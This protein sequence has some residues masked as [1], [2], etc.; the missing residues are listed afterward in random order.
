MDGTITG[1]T[2]IETSGG[3]TCG[4]NAVLGN[5]ISDAVQ[6]AG[7]AR[8]APRA[9]ITASGYAHL[10][11]RTLSATELEAS[12]SAGNYV[13]ITPH[14]FSLF[15]PE[16][17]YLSPWSYYSGNEFTGRIINVDMYGAIAA[18]EQ[19][20]GKKFIY[21]KD[22]EPMLDW[23]EEQDK[24][25]YAVREEIVAWYALGEEEKAKKVCPEEYVK[26]Q[27]PEYIDNILKQKKGK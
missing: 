23:D 26:K 12:D 20:T 13:T 24:T 9:R 7:Y 2:S 10:F 8:F 21:I 3:I 17:D 4:G 14:N 22:E 6:I 27:I 11:A 5:G 15:T 25:Y 18:L 19:L 16:K 1:A